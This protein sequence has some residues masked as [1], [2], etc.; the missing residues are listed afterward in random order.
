MSITIV[1][2]GLLDTVQDNG[3]FGYRYLG[4][5]TGGAMDLFAMHISNIIVGN[6]QGEA[7]L[8]MHF[9]AA[10]LSFNAPC[11]IALTGADFAPTLNGE[12]VPMWQPVAV[13]K[14]SLLQFDKKVSGARVYLSVRGG[15]QTTSW[16]G[17]CSTN[18]QATIG[19]HKGR[20]L[21]KGDEILFNIVQNKRSGSATGKK[22]WQLKSPVYDQRLGILP[23]LH[24]HAIPPK[25]QQVF[26]QQELIVLHQSNRMGYQLQGPVIG[27]ETGEQVSAAVNFG[28]VQSLP[29]GRYTI[30]GADH[31]AT[32]GYPVIGH[33]ITAHHYKLAQ[34]AAGDHVVFEWCS[35]ENALSLWQQQQRYLTQLQHAVNL[36]APE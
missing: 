20:S 15:F 35:Y 2:P 26:M 17:S 30:L 10:V 9:P 18:L 16:L 5:N 12:T 1:R 33:V 28:T 3:R 29:H 8:E 31:Q 19:G 11:T 23:G 6:T 22:R 25:Q 14:N 34:L 13:E 7:V 36:R 32:G 21:L 24:W 27:T 4:I